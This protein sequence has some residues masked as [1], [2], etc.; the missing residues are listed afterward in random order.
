MCTILKNPIEYKDQVMTMILYF[1]EV[2][3]IIAIV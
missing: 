2:I 1:H 3:I